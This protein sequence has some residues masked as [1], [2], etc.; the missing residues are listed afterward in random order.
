MALAKNL[1]SI[2]GS[3]AQVAILQVHKDAGVHTLVQDS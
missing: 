3:W 2:G 1:F